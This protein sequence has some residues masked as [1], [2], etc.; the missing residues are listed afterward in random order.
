MLFKLFFGRYQDGE[1]NVLLLQNYMQELKVRYQTY[2]SIKMAITTHKSNDEDL[3]YR[4]LTLDFGKR[5]TQVAIDWCE[6]ALKNFSLE[7]E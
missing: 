1:N 6:S 3:G 5:T 7:G 2:S 4:L